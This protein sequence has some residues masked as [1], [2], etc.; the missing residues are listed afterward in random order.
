MESSIEEIKKRIDIIEFISSFVQLKKAGRNFKSPCPFHQEKTPSFVVSPDRQIWHCFG[1]CQDGGDIFKF[2]M[3]WENITFFEALKELAEKAGVKLK[4]TEYEDKAWKQKEKLFTINALASQYFEYLLHNSK[5]GEKVLEYLEGRKVNNKI[6]K[7]FSLGYSL[8]SWDGLSHFLSKH[9]FNLN[10]ILETGLIIRGEYGRY[11]DRLRG[12]LIFPIKDV[13]GNT[14]GFSGRVL[15]KESKEAK[16]INTPETAIYHKRETLYGINLAREAIKREGSAIIVEGEFDVISPHQ[17][18][19]ENVAAIKGSALTREQ[20]TLLKRYT[21]RLILSLDA[22]I[23]GE[24]AMKR[25][26]TEATE[27]GFEVYIL[28]LDFAKDPDEAVRKDLNKFKTS[29]KQYIP[30]YDFIINLSLKKNPLTDPF[31][32]KRI[33]EEVIPFIE[34]INNPIIKSHYVRKLSEILQVD[35]NSI[36]ALIREYL[37]KKNKPRFIRK[38]THQAKSELTREIMIQKYLLSSLFQDPKVFLMKDKIFEILNADDFLQP[39]YQKIIKHFFDYMG[40]NTGEFN[41]KAFFNYL[42]RELQTVFDEIYLFAT[43]EP[44]FQKNN[45]E[46]MAYEIK[47]DSLKNKITSLISENST[48]NEAINKK[49]TDYTNMLKEVENLLITV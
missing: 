19:I 1:T 8:N 46:K 38:F 44:E 27:M 45:V 39:S 41:I 43:V 37:K 18:G 22:D 21:D 28:S 20:L 12:R 24:E 33:G 16:Y 47:R 3:K 10:D 32:K 49:I 31:S 5:F 36:N 15:D 2:L 9:K 34:K 48:N 14:V 26:I 30:L 17:F 35:E 29:L 6:A 23:T 11:Y 40:Q 42:P 4:N 25:G 13:R 7:K